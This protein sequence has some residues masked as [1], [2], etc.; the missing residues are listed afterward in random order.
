[1]KKNLLRVSAMSFALCICFG[2]ASC[3]SDA[4]K[5]AP[6]AKAAST[7]AKS[8]DALPNYRYVDLDTVLSKYNL[9]ATS[10]RSHTRLTRTKSTTCR[11]TPNALWQL[12]KAILKT[13]P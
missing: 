11:P 9:A 2:L 7:P 4:Q 5:E 6:A 3:G 8:A 10:R 1:M 13:L 12:C